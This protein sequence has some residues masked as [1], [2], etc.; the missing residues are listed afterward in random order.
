MVLAILF[1][2]TIVFAQNKNDV[3]G[4]WSY[5]APS[6]P[7]G[8][9]KGKIIINLD[10]EKKLIGEVEFQDGYK[11]KMKDIELKDG[12]VIFGMNIDYEY[13]KTEVTVTGEKMEGFV[14][15]PDG[16]LNV[17]AKKEG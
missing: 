13:I 17:T 9:Q 16:K 6:A 4:T 8:Y 7:Y 2:G 12:K 3:V 1:S 14:N 15:S 10:K 11:I 5:E